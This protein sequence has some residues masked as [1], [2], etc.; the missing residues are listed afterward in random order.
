[1][2]QAKPLGQAGR[3]MVSTVDPGNHPMQAELIESQVQKCSTGLDRVPV[4]GNVGMENIAEFAT[5][6]FDRMEKKYDVADQPLRFGKFHTQSQRLTFI[7]NLLPSEIRAQ[8]LAQHFVVHR[9]E[10]QEPTDLSIAP[11]RQERRTVVKSQWSE[12]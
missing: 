12:P 9:L 3:I 11:V 8:P 5:P 10:R 7:G 4:P 6:V 2:T 1:M